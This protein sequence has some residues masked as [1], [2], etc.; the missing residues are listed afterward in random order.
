MVTIW[1][2][3]LEVIIRMIPSVIGMSIVYVCRH[4]LEFS[5]IKKIWKYALLLPTV[6]FL[7]AIASVMLAVPVVFLTTFLRVELSHKM[8][9]L[10]LGVCGLA[11]IPMMFY[12][13][14]TNDKV[15]NW[16]KK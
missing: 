11:S 1:N 14:F 8:S 13:S 7:G 15:K 10:I 5:T 9:E 12:L 4:Y 6:F 16:L 3:L 2:T